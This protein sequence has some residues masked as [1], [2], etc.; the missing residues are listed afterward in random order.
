MI[1]KYLL[2]ADGWKFHMC[3][4]NQNALLLSL[5]FFCLDMSLA[6]TPLILFAIM[7]Y[8]CI[9]TRDRLLV[10]LCGRGFILYVPAWL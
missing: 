7:L 6:V 5:G 9:D 1:S 3:V 2:A 10:S 4:L 8:V